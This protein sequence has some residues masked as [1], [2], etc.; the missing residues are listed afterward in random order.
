[1]IENCQKAGDK[2]EQII[3]N[4]QSSLLGETP[5]FNTFNE[6]WNVIDTSNFT[7][8]FEDRLNMKVTLVL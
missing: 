1:M 3:S 4:Q 6:L 8:H 5:V 2:K 7:Q